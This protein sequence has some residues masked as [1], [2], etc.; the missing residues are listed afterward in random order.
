MLEVN[1][2]VML[3]SIVIY[4]PIVK[5]GFLIVISNS[6]IVT[7]ETITVNNKDARNSFLINY[8]RNCVI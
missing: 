1:Q 3:D 4:N 2:T 6:V 7:W 5:L 8:F